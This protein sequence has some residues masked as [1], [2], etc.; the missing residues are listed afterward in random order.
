MYAYLQLQHIFR[1]PDIVRQ[2]FL[3]SGQIIH[4]GIAMDMRIRRSFADVIMIPDIGSQYMDII[5]IGITG[6]A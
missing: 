6:L 2:Q 3:N 1:Q 4:Q 5:D